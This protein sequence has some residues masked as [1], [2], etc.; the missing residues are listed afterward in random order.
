MTDR[1]KLL[2]ELRAAVDVRDHYRAALSEA[3]ERV[4]L[5]R[6]ELRLTKQW[7]ALKAARAAVKKREQEWR[8]ACDSHD[9]VEG[10]PL[11]GKTGLQLF[12]QA[13]AGGQAAIVEAAPA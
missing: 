9:A 12:D 7:K 8:R 3:Q 1:D 4:G 13:V 10:E 5:M 2:H 11:S 6:S